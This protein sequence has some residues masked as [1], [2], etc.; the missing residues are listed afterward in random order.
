MKTITCLLKGGLA[1]F[2]KKSAGPT[3]WNRH[4]VFPRLEPENNLNSYRV[5]DFPTRVMRNPLGCQVSSGNQGGQVRQREDQGDLPQ[6][7]PF[8]DFHQPYSKALSVLRLFKVVFNKT[9]I[10]ALQI[11]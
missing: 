11:K 3:D 4:P 1:S 7:A 8:N 6:G 2:R 9:E 10:S 5:S